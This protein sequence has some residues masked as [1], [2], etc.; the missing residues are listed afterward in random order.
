MVICVHYWSCKGMVQFSLGFYY[1]KKMLLYSAWDFAV[2]LWIF[3]GTWVFKYIVFAG[4]VL[5]LNENVVPT[6]KQTF[7][8]RMKG[9][10]LS[11]N[12][13]NI[14]W[15][16]SWKNSICIYFWVL[17]SQYQIYISTFSLSLLLLLNLPLLTIGSTGRDVNN[18]LQLQQLVLLI[19]SISYTYIAITSVPKCN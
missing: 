16:T 10:F 6:I 18:V 17:D 12:Y 9:Y 7:I 1:S 5:P 8:L 11:L 13:F 15:E 4:N 14:L 2:Y 19:G 3:V